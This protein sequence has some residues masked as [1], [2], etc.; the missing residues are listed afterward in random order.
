MIFALTAISLYLSVMDLKFHK[1]LNRNLLISLILLAI[2]SQLSGSEL[3]P[4]SAL[5][6]LLCTPVCLK[7]GIGAG[8]LK[9][10]S[11]LAFFFIP[12]SWSVIL[13]FLRAFST[14]SLGLLVIQL[15]R[16]RS[17][18]G[19]IALAP[20]ICGSVIWCAR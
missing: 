13:G 18:A 11:L 3:N 9:L 5:L 14:I 7:L 8:D 19:N 4:V 16:I 2:G 17:L 1:I 15:F 20:A 12:L 10:L 6:V